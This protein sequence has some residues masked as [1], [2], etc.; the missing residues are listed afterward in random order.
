MNSKTIEN[1]FSTKN[2]PLEYV[3]EA[4]PS[5]FPKKII[6]NENFWKS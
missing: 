1:D 5:T 4:N 3:L 2:E 6:V